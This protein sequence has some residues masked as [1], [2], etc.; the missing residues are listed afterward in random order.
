MSLVQ[1]LSEGDVLAGGTVSGMTG[2]AGI[3]ISHDQ[4]YLYLVS[5]GDNQL[6][7][8]SR[9][10]ATG[11]L[12]WVAIYRDGQDNVIGLE[13]PVSVTVSP[14][15]AFVYVAAELP[16]AVVDSGAVAVF[17][18][19]PS[20]GT[21]TFVQRVRD[22]FGSI[23]PD[24]NVIVD[25]RQI[26]ISP[27]GNFMYVN[28]SGSDAIAL[29]SRNTNTGNLTY[30][31]AV[32]E[33]DTQGALTVTG[34]GFVYAMTMSPN[35]E[36][37]Y[38]TGLGGDSVVVFSRDAV[39][40]AL[41]FVKAY[42]QGGDGGSAIDGA[43]ALTLSAQG[44]YLYVAG[45][46]S[47]AVSVFKR[48]WDSGLLRFQYSFNNGAD[49]SSQV[50]EPISLLASADEAQLYMLGRTPGSMVS[51]DIAQEALCLSNTSVGDVMS[52][53]VDMAKQSQ[54]QLNVS[55]TVH[56]SARGVITNTA[57]INTP[58]G[59]VDGN[60]IN[61][62]GTDNNTQIIA[63]SDIAI[64][65]TGPDAPVP[66]GTDYQYVLEVTNAG[67]SDALGATV[68]D[69][70]PLALLSADW[71]CTATAGS[72]C[73]ASGMGD[74]NDT[75]T[76]L[77]GG[78][79]TYT[80]TAS[81]AS[82]GFADVSNTASLIKEPGAIDPDE[83][84]NTATVITQFSEVA[85]VSLLKSSLEPVVVPGRHSVFTLV[86]E[87][88]GPSDARIVNVTDVVPSDYSNVTWTCQSTGTALC[89]SP[90]SGSGNLDVLGAV[91]VG[92]QLQFF[93]DG[94]LDP[95]LTANQITN[96]GVIEIQGVGTDPGA[97]NNTSVYSV[98]VQ[99]QAD[100]GIVKTDPLDPVVIDGS[101][102]SGLIYQLTVMNH[103]PS[104]AWNVHVKDIWP[105]SV[106][107]NNTPDC[108]SSN[109]GTGIEVDCVLGDMLPGDSQ[110][111]QLAG[112]VP[113]GTSGILVNTAI[114]NSDSVDPYPANNTTVE[115]T[116][117]IDNG[118]VDLMVTKSNGVSV[119]TP[120]QAVT[121]RIVVRNIGN[122]DSGTVTVSDVMP[123]ELQGV[124]WT[125]SA[126]PSSS[127]SVGGSGDIADSASLAAG[128][129]IIYTVTANLDAALDPDAGV[130][131]SNSASATSAG[132]T[133]TFNNTATD[134][135]PVV[136]ALFHE[137]FEL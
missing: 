35:G 80:I 75:V 12:D 121:Y 98:P 5:S 114:V 1:T 68:V 115:E 23:A 119:L 107:Y 2:V 109:P 53:T 113:A 19:D 74:I 132:D 30:V 43:S 128:G 125:C 3:A 111:F 55:A 118:V 116:T 130:V 54:T 4:K 84:N 94:V 40:G 27:D 108:I 67:P 11:M 32:R 21:L 117:L 112:S 122:A 62:A 95:L 64:T 7:V 52:W 127:C 90:S 13:G 123:A 126:T 97:S 29:F 92:S 105:N 85:D 59:V 28:G 66:A 133:N 60:M 87:N 89:P 36:Y 106:T 88:A 9:D 47:N 26:L 46:N 15:D 50:L 31:G 71:T 99:F 63:K 33:G 56:P 82:N 51:F 86:V 83:S 6:Q 58:A 100:M 79:L 16:S 120:G 45:L 25:P 131:I 44:T 91:P 77:V 69:N 134:A 49:N 24:S 57:L 103:G 124:S 8:F 38:A 129:A 48:D 18:R 137:N 110:T 135:D 70:I 136:R 61:N 14:D 10:S 22:G 101:N 41:T 102:N 17:Q 34:L 37:L 104:I 96:T 20:T 78:K 93:V 72:S 81:S 39:T 76:V 73:S 42:L 65:K